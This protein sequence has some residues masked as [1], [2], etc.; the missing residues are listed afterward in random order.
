MFPESHEHLEG[1][2]HLI[3]FLIRRIPPE[4]SNRFDLCSSATRCTCRRLDTETIFYPAICFVLDADCGPSAGEESHFRG[5]H[6]L[7]ALLPRK[8]VQSDG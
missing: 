1:G 2:S 7:R 3:C 6:S 4:W 5:R 8:V